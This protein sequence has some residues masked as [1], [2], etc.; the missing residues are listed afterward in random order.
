MSTFLLASLA[1]LVT[2]AIGALVSW[3][4]RGAIEARKRYEWASRIHLE[5]VEQGRAKAASA[6][7]DPPITLDNS[8]DAFVRL[9]DS[10]DRLSV[11]MKANRSELREI[12][13]QRKE[14]AKA[15]NR[16]IA[17]AKETRGA[18]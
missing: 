3:H 7:A 12:V 1:A 5:E 18:Q 11:A 14:L 15:Q 2:G 4:I 17:L 8:A 6:Q 10:V 9:A 16:A 13:E